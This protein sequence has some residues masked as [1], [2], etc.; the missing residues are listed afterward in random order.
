M[1]NLLFAFAYTTPDGVIT[2]GTIR[3]A[4]RAEAISLLKGDT[5][6]EILILSIVQIS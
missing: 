2:H 4:P 5:Q 3:A 6:G 1:A